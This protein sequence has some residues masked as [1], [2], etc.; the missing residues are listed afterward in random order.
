MRTFVA[1]L[2]LQVAGLAI[3]VSIPGVMSITFVQMSDSFNSHTTYA[4]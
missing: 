1:F 3:L 4:I 2:F